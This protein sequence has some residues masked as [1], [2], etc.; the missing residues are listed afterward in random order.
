[1]PDCNGPC[2]V[3]L[4]DSISAG[5]LVNGAPALDFDHSFPGIA[6]A[7]MGV[8]LNDR[9]AIGATCE[10]L[11]SIEVPRAPSNAV[12]VTL[13]CGTNDQFDP[14][15]LNAPGA[16]GVVLAAT[17]AAMP[18]AKIVVV[19]LRKRLDVA[20]WNADELQQA[21]AI[22]AQVV[23]PSVLPASDYPDNIHLNT[24]GAQDLAALVVAAFAK[25]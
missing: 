25:F 5:I 17:H 9:S 7:T 20:A 12:D 3:A 6:A 22:G 2:L 16:F 23:D 1:M 4:G 15:Q 24:Q 8:S 21:A 14:T 19:L 13:D 18:N 10:Q 11:L